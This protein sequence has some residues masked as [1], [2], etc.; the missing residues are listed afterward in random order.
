MKKSYM[1]KEMYGTIKRNITYL[2][3]TV[4][5]VS[6]LFSS[7]KSYATHAAGADLTYRFISSSGNSSTYEVTGTF[8]RDCAGIAAPTTLQIDISSVSC[9]RT[10]QPVSLSKIAGTGQEISFPCSSAVT[11]CTNSGSSNAGFQKYVYRGNITLPAKCTDWVFSYHVCCRNCA[12]TTIT[13][14]SPCG[15]TTEI[16]V[17][18]TLNNLSFPSNNSPTFGNVPVSFICLGQNFTYNHGGNEV[19]GDS[20]YYELVNARSGPSVNVPYINPY[21][22]TNPLNSSP[23]VTINHVNGDLVMNAQAL[24]V[25]I[26]AIRI[27]EYR[28]GILIGSVI[29]D[30]QFIVKN[31]GSNNLPTASGMNGTNKFSATVCA[32]SSI[33]FTV[34]SNDIDAGQ[35]VTMTWDG[36]IS[37]ATFTTAGTPHPTGTFTWN[38]TLANAR[39]QPYQFTVTVQDNSC[40]TNGVQSYGFTI[41]VPLITVSL[42]PSIHNGYNVSC[43]G[44]SNGTILASPSGGTGP[45]TYSWNTSPVQT[46]QTAT[47]L[48]AGS[49]TVTV[50]DSLGCHNTATASITLTQPPAL[51]ASVTSKT[52]VNCFG[53]TTGS[54]TAAGSGGV[55]GYTYSWNTSPVQSTATATGLGSGT[56]TC[57]VTDANG[58][59]TTANATITQPSAALNSSVTSTNNVTCNGNS[60]GVID[61][62]VTGGTAPYS[63]LWSPGGATTQDL[64]ALDTG[65]YSVTVTDSLGCTSTAS[66][67][68]TEPGVLVPLITSVSVGGVNIACY[69]GSTG[70][71]TASATGGTL[72]YSYLWSPSG[73]TAQTQNG[74]SAGTISVLVTDANGC[75]GTATS[76]ITQADSLYSTVTSAINSG[77]TNITCHGASDANID[78]TVNGGTAPY[79]FVW[80]PG[81]NTTEDLANVAAGTYSV[82]ITDTNG[83]IATNSIIITQPDSMYPNISSPINA[84]GYNIGCHGESSGSLSTL[85]V[86][87]TA[88]YS[89]LWTPTN[90][91]IPNL[92]GLPAGTYFLTVTDVNGCIDTASATLTQPDTIVPLITSATVNGGFNISCSGSSNGSASVSVTGGTLPY[93]YSWSTG[94]TTASVSG[95]SAGPITVHVVDANGCSADA[96]ATLTAPPPLN[97]DSVLVSTFYGGNNVSCYGSSNGTIDVFVSG[98]TTPYSYSWSP[99]G[100]TTS[101]LTGLSAGNYT[102]TITDANGCMDSIAIT[103]TQPDTI[104]PSAVYSSFNG[105]P[106]R[107]Y[108]DSTGA[109]DLTVTGGS[110]PFTFAWSNGQTTEDISNLSAGTYNVTIT[111]TNGCSQNFSYTLTQPNPLAVTD[112]LSQYVGGNNISCN[113]FADGSV[114]L[115]VSGG[116][117][118][119]TFSWSSGATTDSVFSLSAGT[120]TYTVTDTNGCAYIDSVTLTQPTPISIA[121]SVSNYNGFNIAC[122]GG[123]DGCITVTASGGTPGYTYSWSN[124]LATA[125]ACNLG[126]GEY[127]ATVTDTNGCSNTIL[128]TL[129]QPDSMVITPL[130]SNYSG[131]NISCNGLSNGTIGVSVTG[132]VP[133][134]SYI[135]SPNADTT[136]NVSGLTAGTYCVHISDANGCSSDSLCITLTEPPAFS[137]VLSATPTSC[138]VDNGTVAASVSGAVPPYTYLWNTLNNDVTPTVD[139]LA[140]GS[141]SVTVT[142]SVGCTF[143]GSV[144]VNNTANFTATASS[145]NNICF[146]G[147]IGTVT[148]IPSGGTPPYHYLWDTPAVDTTATVT[149]LPAGSYNCTLIDSNGCNYFVNAVVQDPLPEFFTAGGVQNVCGD[150]THL[151]A[152]LPL[153]Y[154]GIWTI[155][156]G[157]GVLADSTDPTTL[158]SGLPVGNIALQWTITNGACSDSANALLIT[159]TPVTA[160]AGLN[161]TVCKDSV[162]LAATAVSGYNGTWSVISGSGNF[163][164][165]FDPNAIVTGLAVGANV[166]QWTITN[167]ICTA[168]ATVTVTYDPPTANAGVNQTVCGDSISMTA[169]LPSGFSGTWTVFLG[170][171]TFADATNPSTLVTGLSAGLNVFQWLITDGS[172]SDSATV[173]IIASM[174]VVADAGLNQTVCLDTVDLTATIPGGYTGTWAVLSGSGTFTDIHDPNATVTGLTVGGNIYQWFIT[175]GICSAS[176][177]VTITFD[178]PVANAGVNQNV[179][180]DSTNMTA[181]VPFGYTGEWTVLS[182]SGNFTD[183]TD[184]LTLVTGLSV[185]SNVFQWL[186]TDGSCS[187]SATVTIVT[188]TP[189]VADA[190][191]NQTVCLDTVHL[192]ATLPGGYTGT[193]SVLS[194]SGTFTDIHDPNATV[195]GLTVGNNIYQWFITDGICSASATVTVTYDPPVAYAG[196]DQSVCGNSATMTAT[197]PVGYTGT[198]T[199]V[200]GSANFTST[201]D[202]VTQVDGLSIG[203]NVLQW[204]ITDGICTDS[205]T[206][207]ITAYAPVNATAGAN[208]VACIN[209]AT[210][211]GNSSAGYTGTWTV[212]SGSGSFSP[213]NHDP[214]AVAGPLAIGVNVF[215]WYITNGVCSDSATVTVN[216]TPGTANAGISQN[217][218]GDSTSLAAVAVSGYSGIWTV[219][220]G[221]GT[222]ANDTLYNTSVTGLSF[223]TNVFQWMITNGNCSDS[224]TA[225]VI[226]FAPVTTSAGSSQTV[227]NN[228]A[229]L[230]A[231]NVAGYTGTWTVISGSGT[232]SPDIHDSAAVVTNMTSGNNVFQWTIGNGVCSAT[233]TVTVTYTPSFANAGSNQNVCGD[234]TIMNASLNA[235]YT[236]TWTVISGA[237]TFQNVTDPVSQVHNLG[238]GANVFQWLVTNGICTDSA[239]VTITTSTPVTISAGQ[240]QSVCLN[241]ATLGA[242]ILSGYTGTWSVFSGSGNFQNVNN[243]STIVTQMTSGSNVFQW[244]ITDGICSANDTVTVDYVPPVSNPGFN[245]NICVN[246][247]TM[248]ASLSAGYT[249][250]WSI[251]S[252]TGTFTSTT[253]PLAGVSNLSAGPNVFQWLVTNGTCSDSNIVTIDVSTPVAANAGQSQTICINSTTLSATVISGYS[254]TWT[255]V[256]GTGIFGNASLENTTVTC[257]TGT[258]VYMW[259]ISNG[260][261]SSNDTV[262]VTNTPPLVDPGQLQDVC[263]PTT[264]L[265]AS[266]Q[267]GYTGTWSNLSG[268]GQFSNVNSPTSGVTGLSVGSNSFMW[269]ITNGT[270]TDSARV[271]VNSSS[272][273]TAS[274]GPDST[275][276]LNVQTQYVMEATSPQPGTGTWTTYSGTGKV[277]PA[278]SPSATITP[279]EGLNVLVWTV[280]N[281]A[282]ANSDTV[283]ITFSNGGDCF[284]ELE[285]PTGFSPN[286]N[287]FNDA[288]IIH[289]ID[290]YPENTFKVFNRWGNEVYSKD[291]Y[292][293]NGTEE[294]DW[295]GQNKDG[296]PLPDGTY[297]VVLVIKNS[298]ITR[299]TYVDLRR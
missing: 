101:S 6:F 295:Y 229:T 187:D 144:T 153:G 171:G 194:G 178:P 54:A 183:T 288:Y 141:Y 83:C 105:Y 148:A 63:Y 228:S 278:N 162:Y 32:G 67:I 75:T 267:N 66:T 2:M 175:D 120:Y 290:L 294:A 210:L 239:T 154:T 70:S 9:N 222:F 299:S 250:T 256:S 56:Y 113:G 207:N 16:Y 94:D 51:T 76:V 22:G 281:G 25:G 220:L 20:L 238:V 204:M 86:G 282:C 254:G 181:T 240:S 272:L 29:R 208:Q 136:Q 127:A 298:T 64:T 74:L 31:C 122:F 166:F 168:S 71:A 260:T 52:N 77:G 36:G 216:Y 264:T 219:V 95:L 8:Y 180:G 276:C 192:S 82:T 72:P 163:N 165:V 14:G 60:N 271:V 5:A 81:G 226:A 275:I 236:G 230:S 96:S 34:N 252:G 150:S 242:A 155:L 73:D 109:I 68:I 65:T 13:Q 235:G 115:T 209:A 202:P 232:F 44:G 69:G 110:T 4:L 129:T 132:G 133:A 241:S 196:V 140:A 15:Q 37:G 261:C 42:T 231:T 147:S 184:P 205:A 273:V 131:Y 280:V 119:Y 85:V 293:N 104:S 24:Q 201:S 99:S 195:T 225:A 134:Y 193:W 1:R 118:S 53:N 211:S 255:V 170:T 200:S 33:S 245:Q 218:C 214:N 291:N 233:S 249:G 279:G 212:I 169:L 130:L 159:A 117:P 227:C 55:G 199:V 128:V 12:I 18:A 203:V 258:N 145:T 251:V 93:S 176:A 296:D 156:S 149:G 265:A 152:T 102:V 284:T 27:K 91:T 161:Q 87:G 246:S 38:T 234:S 164:N 259:T 57:T 173:A 112:S 97:N 142:D 41:Y 277:L 35:T 10:L 30:M 108:G 287:G 23:A 206:V 221:T 223:G 111:D 188:S 47:G 78:L 28:N 106:I 89:Y 40:P 263:G 125:T 123:S 292:K 90:D 158:I 139:S 289:G 283:A 182:G 146:G 107:C 21:S 103:L 100:D 61:L 244:T 167:G 190:G 11:T 151:A 157:S 62:T 137:V 253:N 7:Q 58:C 237:G 189:V 248:N 116:V 46:T 17:E 174:P 84:G 270:C 92:T 185:G 191:V 274:A 262:S 45:Y 297:F 266:L 286:G 59:T 79:A 135:W 224:S 215:Q 39:P 124:E 3:G 143:T 268:T 48:G 114:I 198:W 186:I 138:G 26:A 50:T 247:T 177:N 257:G 80:T 88:P 19:D 179:C 213:D 243:P 126:A 197:L 160:D 98:G 217:V 172:C 121:D 269:T 285:L 49:Y 43:N